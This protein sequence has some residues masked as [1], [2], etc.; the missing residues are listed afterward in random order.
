[1]KSSMGIFDA[2]MGARSNEASGKAIIARQRESDVSN[3]HF[4]DNATRSIRHTGNV[5][6]DLI[7]HVY[8]EQRVMRIMGED[9]TPENV[10]VNAEFE[11]PTGKTDEEGNP[12]SKIY[13][14]TVGKYDVTVKAGPSFTTRREEAAN[15]MIELLRAFPE[16]APMIGDILADALDWPR[17]D[18]ISKRLKRLLP[19]GIADSEEQQANPEADALRA[20]MEQ[21]L[22]AYQQQTAMLDGAH[23][24][25]QQLQQ[26]IANLE[27]KLQNE[28]EKRKIDHRK[29]DIEAYKAENE[30]DA[31]VAE[32]KKDEADA[33]LKLEQ[34]KNEGFD[35][36]V[37]AITL[38][39][40]FQNLD[41]EI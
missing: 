5:V 15:Q 26:Q 13:D 6:L 8:S 31:T 21:G 28:D 34:A 17:A 20:E 40:S 41:N 33:I 3:F 1:M 19:P 35:K 18:E 22:Q 7:P 14:L 16:A 37:E 2:A 23:A 25:L 9:E 30:R 38:S 39:R 11:D 10:Q 27:A 36:Q 32:A 12:I 4:L 24:Q 29:L